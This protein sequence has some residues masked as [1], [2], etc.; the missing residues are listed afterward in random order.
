MPYCKL[1]GSVKNVAIQLYCIHEMNASPMIYTF[2][3]D[4]YT[5]NE[6][7]T[8]DVIEIKQLD[9][10]YISIEY[11]SALPKMMALFLYII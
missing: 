8:W 7:F 1:Y 3:C 5:A 6:N 4:Q 10:E 2:S 9:C 11:H